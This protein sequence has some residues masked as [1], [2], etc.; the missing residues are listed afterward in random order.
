MRR[1][2]LALALSLS[3]CVAVPVAAAQA[4]A[5][6]PTFLGGKGAKVKPKTIGVGAKGAFE[7]LRWRNWGKGNAYGKGIYDIAGFATDPGSGY[8]SSIRLRAYR[9]K[10]CGGGRS[11]YTR[12]RYRIG[13]P[14]GGKRLFSEPFA[15]CGGRSGP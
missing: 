10:D 1:T 7:K 4:K 5:L 2:M 6:G 15:T 13:K 3:I 8:R 12:V 14:I 11:V 9:L